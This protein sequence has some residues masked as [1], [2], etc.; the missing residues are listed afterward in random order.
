MP[1][2]VVTLDATG[3]LDRLEGDTTHARPRLREIDDRTELV[4]VDPAHHRD[5]QGCREIVRVECIERAQAG[6][7]QFRAT[8]GLQRV[9]AQR[10]E[11]QVDL[12]AG[13]VVGEATHEVR[14]ARDAKTIRVQHQ[15]PDRA[16]ARGIE[17]LEELRM[18]GRL[19]PGQLDHVGLAFGLHHGIEH[20]LDGREIAVARA[21]R[22]GIGVA[23]RATQV[24]VV[25]QFDQRQAGM[26]HVFR[27]QAAV[28]RAAVA[29]RGR[30]MPRQFRRL[31]PGLAGGTVIGRIIGDQHTLAAVFRAPLFQVHALVLD[32]DLG[33]DPH[34]A[35]AAD[36]DRAVVEQVGTDLAHAGCS[37]RPRHMRGNEGK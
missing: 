15:V 13:A 16:A 37:D 21:M 29:L 7:A 31:D 4:V 8:Q 26:L 22:T 18:Q 19:A 1:G 17:H 36:R 34:Q 6:V 12:E 20:A 33:L 23:D 24:A 32:Q 28:V 9:L 11:L 3:R 35:G 14:L 2:G 30:K 10:I 27:T 5:H 25:G